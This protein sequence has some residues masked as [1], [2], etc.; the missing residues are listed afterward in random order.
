MQQRLLACVCLVHSCLSPDLDQQNAPALYTVKQRHNSNLT[1]LI[2]V[3]Q[4]HNTQTLNSLQERTILSLYFIALSHCWTKCRLYE[5]ITQDSQV[6]E[7]GKN[8]LPYWQGAKRQKY[9]HSC[10]QSI[11][12][13]FCRNILTD[14]SLLKRKKNLF[15]PN[16][17]SMYVSMHPL[18]RK[19]KQFNGTS[20]RLW[21]K[22]SSNPFVIG[23]LTWVCLF[24]SVKWG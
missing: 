2:C 10:I 15:S 11:N 8:F 16:K 1:H 17:A 20:K 18:G 14:Q 5:V 7:K 12:N 24:P 21:D 23:K 9:A 19:G 6:L 13:S 4:K 3:G 22:S